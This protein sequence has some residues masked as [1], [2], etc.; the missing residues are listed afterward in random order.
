MGRKFQQTDNVSDCG[1]AAFCSGGTTAGTST[2]ELEENGTIGTTTLTPGS[3]PASSSRISIFLQSIAGQPNTTIWHDGD[4][5]VRINVTT[6]DMDLRLDEVH[7]CRIDGTG[8]TNIATVGSATGLDIT[9]QT[10]G[11][12]TV[13]VP[14]SFQSAGLGDDFVIIVIVRNVNSMFA[15]GFSWDNDQIIDTPIGGPFPKRIEIERD[16]KDHISPLKSLPKFYPLIV[17]PFAIAAS[18]NPVIQS[19]R[20]QWLGDSVEPIKSTPEYYPTISFVTAASANIVIKYR[21]A[22]LLGQRR[23]PFKPFPKYYPT[24]PFIA[25]SPANPVVPFIQFFSVLASFL[26]DRKLSSSAW[27]E[28]EVPKYYPLIPPVQ[29]TY[30]DYEAFLQ[31]DV[32]QYSP[33]PTFIFEALLK[34]DGSW[35]ARARLFNITDNQIVSGSEVSTSETSYD[36]V[37][38][39]SVTLSGTKEYKAQVGKITGSTISSRGARMVVQQ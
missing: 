34:T 1:T 26:R 19:R 18:A 16:F 10:N 5:V 17:A 12:K 14:G 9:L 4:W 20:G 29:P 27:D 22:Q 11:V 3:I 25:T 23:E 35:P 13:T 15:R 6:G 24:I 38:S 28:S 31:I 7:I 32:P 39:S 33:S 2:A 37:R 30:E 36:L 21:V 8:C